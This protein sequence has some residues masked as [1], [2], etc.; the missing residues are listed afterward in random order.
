GFYLHAKN[1]TCSTLKVG[2]HP[3]FS[4]EQIHES[5]IWWALVQ[6]GC[7][8]EEDVPNFLQHKVILEDCLADECNKSFEV[9]YKYSIGE[10][11]YFRMIPG[12]K[13]F[14]K[15]KQG[16]VL[17]TSDGACITSQWEGR[18]FMPLYHIQSNDGF[19]VLREIN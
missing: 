16:E 13:N 11:E 15:I 7:L 10:D 18:I 1:Y 5:A 3:R 14:Q 19:F 9:V 17:A 12:Y 8:Q 4:A 6:T 2:A